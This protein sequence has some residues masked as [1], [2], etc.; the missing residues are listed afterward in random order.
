MSM[1]TATM[2]LLQA[3]AA[4]APAQAPAQTR[5]N[6]QAQAKAAFDAMDANKDGQVDNAEAQRAFA[7]RIS[8]AESRAKAQRDAQFAKI[9]A[10]KDGSI[11]KQEFDAATA[12]RKPAPDAAAKASATWLS[13]ADGDKNGRVSLNEA[14]SQVLAAFDRIDA[15]KDGTLTAAEARAPRRAAP[16]K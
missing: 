4:Q 15:N 8:A 14:T 6:A 16:K 2:I 13:T 1:I 9:D 7:A 11:S 5:A 10:N 3:A 12:G